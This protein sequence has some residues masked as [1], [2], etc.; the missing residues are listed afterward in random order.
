VTT[1]GSRHRGAYRVD[2]TSSA[3]KDAAR[4]SAVADVTAAA[5]GDDLWFSN[6][7]FVP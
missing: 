5:E 7:I 4:I 6:R 2:A 3:A 1:S